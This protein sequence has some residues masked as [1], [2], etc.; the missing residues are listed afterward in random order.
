MAHP[1]A[2]EENFEISL[3][4]GADH[5]WNFVG[6]HTVHGNGPIAMQSKLG[7]LFSGPL[8]QYQTQFSSGTILHVTAAYQEDNQHQTNFW[9]MEPTDTTCTGS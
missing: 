7:Y 4:I 3:L 9:N 8:T 2:Y 1:I 6:D 5:H